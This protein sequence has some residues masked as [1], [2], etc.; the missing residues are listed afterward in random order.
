MTHGGGQQQQRGV[1][2]QS[3]SSTS[4]NRLKSNNGNGFQHHHQ[5]PP[6]PYGNHLSQWDHQ[7]QQPPSNLP[8]PP[9]T[10]YSQSQHT[11]FKNNSRFGH[12]NTILSGLLFLGQK[13][14]DLLGG[15][16]LITPHWERYC[17]LSFLTVTPLSWTLGW[18]F[19]ADTAHY[20]P[21]FDEC[22]T[23]SEWVLA[24]PW[25]R[26]HQDDTLQPICEFQV[27]FPLLRI[28]INQDKP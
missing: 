2:S 13:Y 12:T 17:P 11:V 5:L 15:Q 14:I 23:Q 28:R 3:T 10:S 20:S 4:L 8:A 26:A 25:E 16:T 18:H 19:L 9:Q 6:P 24:L 27:S 1:G 7:K 21:I 22:Q